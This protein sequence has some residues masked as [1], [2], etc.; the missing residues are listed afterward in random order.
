MHPEP[1]CKVYQNINCMESFSRR[2]I[3]RTLMVLGILSNLVSSTLK[4]YLAFDIEQ[5][6]SGFRMNLKR[7]QT[8]QKIA[9]AHQCGVPSIIV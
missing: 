5:Y 7:Y 1:D 2:L 3:N 6:I 8:G 4:R 9:K